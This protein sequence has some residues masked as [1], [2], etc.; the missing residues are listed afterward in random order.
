MPSSI[1][2]ISIAFGAG[3]L[4]AIFSVQM[5]FPT[6]WIGGLGLL[7]WTLI[8]RRRW[9]QLRDA[10]GLEPGAPER[11]VRYYAVGKALIL[12]HLLTAIAYPNETLRVGHGNYLAVDSWTMLGTMLVIYFFVRKVDA[13]EDER[14]RIFNSRATRTGFHFLIFAVVAFAFFLGF[15]FPD[16]ES[17]LTPFLAG[18]ILIAAIVGSFLV[19][20]ISL[21]NE[22]TKDTK[23]T[24]PAG[25]T[26]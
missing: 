16:W 9:S 6:G 3:I 22:Y 1:V 15:A 12:G 2:A 18:N 13:L 23:P 21:L 5:S 11:V 14:D 25:Q 10:V 24:F 4:L 17:E 8:S 19:K 7:A 20:S 26:P